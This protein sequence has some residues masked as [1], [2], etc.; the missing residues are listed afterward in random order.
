MRREIIFILTVALSIMV[1]IRF[2]TPVSSPPAV[3][4]PKMEWTIEDSKA[5]AQDKLY[6][7]KHKQWNCLNKLWTKESNWRPNAYNKIKVMGKNA[8]GIPQILGLDPKTPAP[9]QI[10]RGL[11]YIYNRYVTPC[12]AWEFFTKKGYY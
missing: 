4:D 12:K 7:F 3:L 8:G 9:K 11:S 10:D 1:G 2:A 6:D 5:Y